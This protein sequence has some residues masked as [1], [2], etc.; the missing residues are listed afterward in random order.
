MKRARPAVISI[1]VVMIILNLIYTVFSQSGGCPPCFFDYPPRTGHGAASDGRIKI[2]VY[3]DPSWN[4]DANG[5]TTP[6]STNP[7]VWNGV[8]GCQGCPNQGA[9]QAWDTATGPD[10]VSLVPYNM[11]LTG[12]G[13]QADIKIVR[14][15]DCTTIEGGC[16]EMLANG[17]LRLCSLY[18]AFNSTDIEAI[19]KHE[20]GHFYGL[21]ESSQLDVCASTTN[22]CSGP[23]KLDT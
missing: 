6:G 23:L 19:L 20:V 5:N 1:L 10:G 21:A 12:D 11:E 16:A 2:N 3:I 9:M 17:T 18:R 13:S 4:I 14:V 22:T 8:N 7:N 15:L